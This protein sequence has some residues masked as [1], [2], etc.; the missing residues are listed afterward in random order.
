MPKCTCVWTDDP[1][2]EHDENCPR[3]I[4]LREQD[5]NARTEDA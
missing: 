5:A 4:Y 1:D 2:Q 3:E